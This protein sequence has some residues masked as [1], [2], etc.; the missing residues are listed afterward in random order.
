MRAT[1]P[2]FFFFLL[3]ALPLLSK[4]QVCIHIFLFLIQLCLHYGCSDGH[5]RIKS[6]L[7]WFTLNAMF[8]TYRALPP[9]PT[10]SLRICTMATDHWASP[11]PVHK[12]KRDN[13]MRARALAS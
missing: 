8:N 4:G 1:P 13:E 11:Y 9:F 5:H 2:V 10:I 3:S 6:V 7:P 12:R